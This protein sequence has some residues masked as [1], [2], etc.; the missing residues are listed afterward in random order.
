MYIQY[1]HAI[2][3]QSDSTAI[4]NR[5][6]R[7]DL[8][9]T[10]TDDVTSYLTTWGHEVSTPDAV[11]HCSNPKA[12]L[13]YLFDQTFDADQEH[14]FVSSAASTTVTVAFNETHFVNYVNIFQNSE[15]SSTFKVPT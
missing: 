9:T 2:V 15:A 10:S 12:R 5:G 4:E 11:G 7:L 13:Q 6:H 14:N 3:L 8:T 1:D